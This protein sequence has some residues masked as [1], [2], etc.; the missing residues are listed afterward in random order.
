M[1]LVDPEKTAHPLTKETN[2]HISS[3]Q[4]SITML[5]PT[6]AKQTSSNRYEN[7]FADEK[8]TVTDSGSDI[9]IQLKNETRLKRNRPEQNVDK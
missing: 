9:I 1:P 7:I 4:S 3:I 8:Q 2:I 6:P 5:M